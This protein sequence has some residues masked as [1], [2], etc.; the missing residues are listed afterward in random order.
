MTQ[1][2]ILTS[3]SQL[4]FYFVM[5][6]FWSHLIPSGT[7]QDMNKYICNTL[8]AARKDVLAIA[9]P[10]RMCLSEQNKVPVCLLCTERT[11]LSGQLSFTLCGSVVA[12]QE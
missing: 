11:T 8:E 10:Y 7:S 6:V 1:N 2:C 9:N 12:Q 3:P 5:Y 4:M